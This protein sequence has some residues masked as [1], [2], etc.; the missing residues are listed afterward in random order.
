L[1]QRLIDELL[2]GLIDVLGGENLEP[3]QLEALRVEFAP[4]LDRVAVRLQEI[5]K[6]P[7]Q[8]VTT[9]TEENTM[10]PDA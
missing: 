8:P 10:T 2:D 4:A 7:G 5:R 3:D 9:C 6:T 1:D